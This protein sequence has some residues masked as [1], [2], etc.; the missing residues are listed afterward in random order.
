MGQYVLANDGKVPIV[1]KHKENF[2]QEEFIDMYDKALSKYHDKG[3]PYY[4][5]EEV[6]TI[7]KAD[8]G[9]E[10]AKV[11]AIIIATSVYPGLFDKGQSFKRGNNAIQTPFDYKYWKENKII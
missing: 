7:L 8:Y 5:Q 6:S 10:D 4:N 2:S 9:F 1:L 3:V 11:E